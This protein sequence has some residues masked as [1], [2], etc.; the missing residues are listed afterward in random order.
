MDAPESLFQ[1][2]RN[3]AAA[4]RARRAAF[5]VDGEAYFDA[6][7][8][9]TERARRSILVCGWDFDSRTVLRFGPDGAPQVVLGDWLN[10]LAERHKR[11][12]I[13]SLDWDYPMIFGTD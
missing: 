7:V 13:R 8:R 3:C 2:G 9:A 4:G 12:V 11:L 1:P 5:L 6:F 10:R